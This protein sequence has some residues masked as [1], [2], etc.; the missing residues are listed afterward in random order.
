M[1]VV[2]VVPSQAAPVEPTSEALGEDGLTPSE[3]QRQTRERLVFFSDAVVAIAMTLLALELPVPTGDSG[4]QIWDSFV[5]LL[6]RD[7]LMFAISFAVTAGFWHTHHR[8]F[9]HIDRADGTL[10]TLNITCLLFIV[11]LPF[12]SRVL[13]GDGSHPFGVIFY[14]TMIIAVD[15]SFL[16]LVWYAGRHGL[17]RPGVQ[18]AAMRA[19]AVSMVTVAAVFLVSI[20]VALINPSAGTYCWLSLLVIR[21]LIRLA[22]RRIAALRH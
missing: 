9:Q 8:L 7:Y 22:A 12:A 2:D 20:P 16:A 19:M 1:P 3:S 18:P 14:A 11:L 15:L 13:I 4:A 5:H 6:S 21:R 10:A 17:V